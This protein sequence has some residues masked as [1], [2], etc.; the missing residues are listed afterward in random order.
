MT[1]FKLQ[2]QFKAFIT[3]LDTI[4]VPG[5]INEALAVPQLYP[6]TVPSVL[7][8]IVKIHLHPTCLTPLALGTMSYVLFCTKAFNSSMAA[9][10]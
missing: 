5:D 4:S 10:L 2:S 8:L 6:L 9:S 3:N 7:Y 1:Y